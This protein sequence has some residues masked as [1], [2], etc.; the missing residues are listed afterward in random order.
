MGGAAQHLQS[1]HRFGIAALVGDADGVIPGCEDL[2]PYLIHTVAN[3]L[4]AALYV[5]GPV[6]M[7][8]Y[9]LG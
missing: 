6:A 3:V 9:E 1:A 4:H 8:L 2:A 7:F 5:R